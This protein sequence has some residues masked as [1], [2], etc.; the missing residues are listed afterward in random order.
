MNFFLWTPCTSKKESKDLYLI[1]LSEAFFLEQ[2]SKSKTGLQLPGEC[3]GP[4]RN[5][6]LPKLD[7]G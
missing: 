4:V 5:G 3:S 7:H 2:Q 6:S 1:F